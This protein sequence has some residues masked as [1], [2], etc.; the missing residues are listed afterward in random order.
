MKSIDDLI[1][2]EGGYSDHPADKGGPTMYGIT[3][4]KAR[5]HGYLGNMRDMPRTLAET[6]YMGEYWIRTNISRLRPH[7]V[8][9]EVL[10]SAVLHGP[11]TAIMWLQVALNAFNDHGK[12]YADC[13]TDGILGTKTLEIVAAYMAARGKQDGEAVLVR[14]LNCLQGAYMIELRQEDFVFGWIRHRVSV[15]RGPDGRGGHR[16]DSL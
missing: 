10:D 8:A 12:L 9:E 3:E 5:E 16:V 1:Q 13:K 2:R 6:I 14:A 11:G 15:A 4:R 7:S